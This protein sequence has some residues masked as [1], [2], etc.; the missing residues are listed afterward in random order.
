MDKTKAGMAAITMVRGD[1]FF[2]RRWLD[3]YGKQLGREHLYILNH[4]GDA[5]IAA[6]A[7]GAN[8]IYLPYDESRF[9]WNQR[10][11]QMLSEFTTAFTRH[12]NW[13][14]CGDVDE[15]VAV[16]PDV[17]GS[18]PEYIGRFA[19]GE[20]P[21]VITPFAIELVHNPRLEPEA[22][23]DDAGILARR[24]IFR[25][26]ANYA[27]PC[28]TRNR[29]TFAPGG[30][31]A[32]EKVPFL[33]PHLY[34]FHL[35]FVDFAMTHDR[36]ALRLEQRNIQ[37]GDLAEV[38]RK[39]TGWDTAWSSYEALSKLDPSAETVEFPEFRREMQEGWRLKEGTP[40]WSVGGGRSSKVYRLPER[41][42]QL[43]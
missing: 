1:H 27:K 38:E 40:F 21:R 20:A 35:R 33:D 18:L 30:H 32:S 43:F 11:W 34:L 24:R 39:V 13:V 19:E 15:I 5:G 9:S 41:F 10:R 26:N 14:L 29:I 17:A 31:F 16:D 6:M 12:Y 4:G 3:Y 22:L 37:S 42:A 36:L 25:L 28:I 8:V 7:E 2:L 23:S